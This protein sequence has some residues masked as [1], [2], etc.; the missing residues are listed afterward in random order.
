MTRL[1][2]DRLPYAARRWGE[3][4]SPARGGAAATRAARSGFTLVEFA[5]AMVLLGI[6]MSGLFPLIVMHSRVLQS[7]ERRD[8]KERAGTSVPVVFKWYL[9]PFSDQESQGADAW[10]RKLGVS[11]LVKYTD[12]S[13]PQTFSDL[14]R[15]STIPLDAGGAD[16]S[17]SGD[18]SDEAV[19]DAFNHNQHSHPGGTP[20]IAIWTFAVG[21]AG[22]YQVQATG[23]VPGTPPPGCTY[24]LGYSSSS[25]TLPIPATLGFG[26][27]ASWQTLTTTYLPAGAVTVQLNTGASAAAIADGM[28]IV[29][30]S[31]Q[32]TSLAPIPP[33]SA[34]ATAIVDIKPT[35]F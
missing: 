20:A 15:G 22:W 32:I 6:A 11:A 27:S 25:L 4:L 7:L 26:A 1:P 21:V 8:A 28:Q 19:D 33:T 2:S 17:E 30:C 9:V 29:P 16:Y 12:P 5:V 23:L 18:W 14:A 31:L 3:H 10:A 24:T 34:S 35:T 13:S